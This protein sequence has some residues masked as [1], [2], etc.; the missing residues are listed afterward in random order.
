MKRWVKIFLIVMAALF[1]PYES[2]SAAP[3]ESSILL[4]FED[5]T[6]F[7]RIP[8]ADV[9]SSLMLEKMKESGKF[10]LRFEAPVTMEQSNRLEPPVAEHGDEILSS[11]IAKNLGTKYDARFAVYGKITRLDARHAV[12]RDLGK[13]A[14]A[15][16]EIANIFSGG[17]VG[18]ILGMFGGAATAKDTLEAA[19]HIYVLDLTD[20]RSIWDKEIVAVEKIS[21]NGDPKLDTVTLASGVTVNRTVA[22]SLESIAGQAVKTLIEEVGT[23]RLLIK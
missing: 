6:R 11:E 4:R 13:A 20:G 1:L 9:L 15:A 22:R 16:G 19:T 3:V 2:G 18:S 12:Y 21:G 10:A 7:C 8:S 23:N 5:E 17:I 14:S